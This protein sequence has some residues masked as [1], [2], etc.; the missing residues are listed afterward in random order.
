MMTPEQRRAAWAPYAAAG[1]LTSAEAKAKRNGTTVAE[2]AARER[3]LAR[4]ALAA[5]NERVKRERVR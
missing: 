2:E 4:R 5:H 3:A 1:C